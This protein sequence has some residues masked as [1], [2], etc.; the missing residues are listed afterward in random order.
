MNK[1]IGS[2]TRCRMFTKGARELIHRTDI[3]VRKDQRKR[4]G[5]CVLYGKQ[6]RCNGGR[7]WFEIRNFHRSHNI[8]IQRR[9]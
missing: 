4:D 9:S 1:F 2:L 5:K 8:Y 6:G 3:P 7:H